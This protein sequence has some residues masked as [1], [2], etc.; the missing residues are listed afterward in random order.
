MEDNGGRVS[1]SHYRLLI[2]LT[3]MCRVTPKYCQK[4]A[5]SL[6]NTVRNVQFLIETPSK[7]CYPFVLKGFG[8]EKKCRI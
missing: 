1:L 8:Y 3:K 7:M 6:Q 4:C 5:E 2:N